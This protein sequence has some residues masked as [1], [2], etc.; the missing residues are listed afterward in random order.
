MNRNSPS[1]TNLGAQLSGSEQEHHSQGGKEC[2]LP[3]VVAPFP[4]VK[5]LQVG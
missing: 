3:H 4:D 5:L 2:F 1:E